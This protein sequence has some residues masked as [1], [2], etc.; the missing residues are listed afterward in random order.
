MALF[1]LAF[2]SFYTARLYALAK[3]EEKVEMELS[4][5]IEKEERLRDEKESWQKDCYIEQKARLELGLARPGETV[6][7]IED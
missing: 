5:Y 6:I 7:I 1:L 4:E 2:F 3:E